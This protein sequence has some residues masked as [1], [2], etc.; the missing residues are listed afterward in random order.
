M[1]APDWLAQAS[2]GKFSATAASP[3]PTAAEIRDAVWNAAKLNYT[4]PG[5]MGN[6]MLTVGDFWVLK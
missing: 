6:E 2:H 5:T 4:T 1:A 3:Y